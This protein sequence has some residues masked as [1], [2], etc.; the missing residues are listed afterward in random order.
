MIRDL[1][2]GYTELEGLPDVC[3]V[4]A[5]AAGIVLAVELVRRG[6]SVVMIEGGG[7]ELEA[8]AQDPYRSEIA[9][10][11]HRGVH[12]G[13]FRAVG[14]TTLKWG[15]QILELD[16]SDFA[17][18]SGVPGSGWPISK[19][20]LTPHYERALEL[21]GLARVTRDDE[22]VWRQIGL[23]QAR[24]ESLE[25]YFSR[26]CPQPN[27]AILHQETLRNHPDLTLWQHANAVEL[28]FARNGEKALVTGV[29]ARTLTGIERV[30]RARHFVFC[31]GAIESSRFFLQPSPAGQPWNRSG[32]LGKHFQ[33]HIDANV[34][35]ALPLDR[36][37]FHRCF[38]NVFSNGF[39]YHPKLRLSR[40]M[41]ASRNTL[42]VAG[43]MLFESDTEEA[44]G[45]LK[46]TAKNLL[47]GQL[48]LLGGRDL[49]VVLNNLP[50]LLRQTWRYGINH[51][52]YNPEE[53][54][55]RLRVHCE[56]LPDSRSSITLSDSRDALGLLRTRLDWQIAERELETIRQY[57]QVAQQSLGGVARLL[58]DE[59][60]TEGDPAFVTRCD[61]SNHHMGGMR[62]SASEASGLVD[63]QLQLYGTRNVSVCSSAVF[64]TSGYSN[65]THTL[66][67]LAVRL[68][69]HLS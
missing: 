35:T 53:A 3:I 38:D 55:I 17:V 68:A 48:G 49:R 18:R 67:A 26:W 37:R 21:E 39:K 52:A 42:N 19:S 11:P 6:K 32:L 4:G 61:D 40:Q 30:V 23:T 2:Q 50:L 60:L 59:Q 45:Q 28:L 47:R 13:R 43:T 56:Q 63:P 5:G 22:A 9:G 54:T 29:R 66:L 34:A 15:G 51:R 46:A 33:D 12:T 1:L 20:E 24:F 65:P 31:L 69:A 64:P 36:A 57:V 25:P 41:Q 62:M 8:E 14:G 16:E 58:P 10:L 27:F 44:L 7:I